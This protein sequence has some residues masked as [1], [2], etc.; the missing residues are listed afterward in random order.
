[1]VNFKKRIAGIILTLVAAYTAGNLFLKGVSAY[2]YQ[3]LP[4]EQKQIVDVLR[5][6]NISENEIRGNMVLFNSA[7]LELQDAQKFLD[8]LN[9]DASRA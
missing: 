7:K 1:M 2:E 8:D 4:K 9:W 6:R 5:K 3:R